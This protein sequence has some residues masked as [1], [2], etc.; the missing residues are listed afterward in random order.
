MAE[1]VTGGDLYRLWRVSDVHL[2]RVADV[3]YDAN[4]LLGG[5]AG[6]S[7]AFRVNAYAY[8]GA[9]VMTSAIGA[10]WQ[11]L[12][13]ELQLTMAQV[14]DTVLDAARGVRTAA[15]V[16]NE[17]DIDNAGE[18]LKVDGIGGKLGDYLSRRIN[19]DPGDVAS[20]PPS[21]GSGED[22]GIPDRTP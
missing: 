7:D 19:H 17:T 18:L 16:Y 1:N 11:E 21:P 14:G 6:G 2:P 8:P 20:N 12:R 10:A 9:S 22:Y 13:G 15:L 5:A 3:F 4:R